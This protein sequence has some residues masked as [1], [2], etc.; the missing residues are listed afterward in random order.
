MCFD[1]YVLS[2]I[3][4]FVTPWTVARQAP[5]SVGFPRQEYRSGL[6][7][8]S[9]LIPIGENKTKNQ[10]QIWCLLLRLLSASSPRSQTET[11]SR[12]ENVHM[13]AGVKQG[14]E[15]DQMGQMGKVRERAT[16]TVMAYGLL[17]FST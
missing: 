9:P 8:P 17:L 4:L 14:K 3:R 2:H 1:S 12:V 6:P 10:K 7:F 16:V 13:E 15:S 11:G 5:L